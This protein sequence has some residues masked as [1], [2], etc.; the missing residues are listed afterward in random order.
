MKRHA[1]TVEF[2]T[3]ADRDEPA[4]GEQ[5]TRTL[6]ATGFRPTAIICVND[7]MA[8]GVL[9]AFGKVACGFPKTCP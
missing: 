3:V 2:T 5:A 4:G 1:G 9:K 7:Y 6:L 8:L